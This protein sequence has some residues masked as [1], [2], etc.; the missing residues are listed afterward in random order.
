MR[1]AGP[2]S[3]RRAPP[4]AS[5]TS[6]ARSSVARV[7][8]AAR[9]G[10]RREVHRRRGDGRLGTPTAREDDAE[11]PSG[12]PSSWSTPSGASGP[13]HPGAAAVLT[14]EAAVT[15]GATNQGMV[16]GDLVNTA[17]AP[18]VRGAAGLRPR[19]R[20]DPAPAARRSS[21]SRGRAVPQGQGRAGPGVARAVRVVA[22][23]GG[24]GRS[25]ALEAPFVGRDD[26]LRSLKDLFHATGR[27]KR[28]RLVSVI[29]LAA[30]ARAGSPGS[31]RSTSTASSRTSSGTAADPCLRRGH[32]LLGA[33]RDDPRRA[34]CRDDDEATT[35]EKLAE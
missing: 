19:R 16:A 3:R 13:G 28:A 35:R 27:E 15:I 9:H 31:S 29:G 11:R 10:P 21:S 23:A 1:S 7:R 34:G 32:H 6:R 8:D 24:R 17:A 2:P 14:G 33:G 22:G 4:V 30:S 25:D 12:P 26:E 5:R 20:G 18:A